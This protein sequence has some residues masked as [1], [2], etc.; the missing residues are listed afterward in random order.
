M[1]VVMRVRKR[2]YVSQVPADDGP[3]LVGRLGAGRPPAWLMM[4]RDR[5][6]LLCSRLL[7]VI[8]IT[9]GIV[10]IVMVDAG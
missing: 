10:V 9:V 7:E 3:W 5:R 2:V 4:V 6:R 1:Y 8:N